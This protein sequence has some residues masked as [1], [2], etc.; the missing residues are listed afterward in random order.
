MALT[1]LGDAGPDTVKVVSACLAG[2][3]DRRAAVRVEIRFLLRAAS[4]PRAI[5]PALRFK[6]WTLRRC[7]VF[8]VMGKPGRRAP[9][10]FEGWLEDVERT[11]EVVRAVV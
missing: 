5:L 6:F 1:M 8:V 3:W 10:D 4:H 9:D 7:P 2:G 11:H